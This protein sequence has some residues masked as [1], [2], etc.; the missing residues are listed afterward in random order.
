MF[1]SIAE[2]FGGSSDY[3][4]VP[5]RS[6]DWEI[7]HRSTHREIPISSMHFKSKLFSDCISG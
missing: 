4:G 3:N 6:F 5:V 7:Y 1:L 2:F